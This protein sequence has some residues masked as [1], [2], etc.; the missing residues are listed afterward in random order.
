MFYSISEHYKNINIFYY[1][2]ADKELDWQVDYFHNLLRK[3]FLQFD[4]NGEITEEKD[5]LTPEQKEAL[6]KLTKQRTLTQYLKVCS[7]LICT[8]FFLSYCFFF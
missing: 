7:H 3:I 4:K 5:N 1:Y 6:E 8:I 2:R